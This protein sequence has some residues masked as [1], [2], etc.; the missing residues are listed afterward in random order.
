MDSPRDHR[1]SD[2]DR[3]RIGWFLSLARFLARWSTWITQL[4]GRR[5]HAMA[6][7]SW[8]ADSHDSSNTKRRHVGLPQE[9]LPTRNDEQAVR[10]AAL[11]VPMGNEPHEANR[12]DPPAPTTNAARNALRN[13]SS[14]PPPSP[15]LAVSAP[16]QPSNEGSQGDQSAALS[17]GEAASEL[18]LAP[19]AADHEA[20]PALPIGSG[21]ATE[22]VLPGAPNPDELEALPAAGTPDSANQ[23]L[24]TEAV[25]KHAEARSSTA[26]TAEAETNSLPAKTP[27]PAEKDAALEADTIDNAACDSLSDLIGPE[28]SAGEDILPFP[29]EA[30]P[31][32]PTSIPRPVSKYRPRLGPRPAPSPRPAAAETEQEQTGGSLEAILL[33]TFLPG[34]WGISLAVLLG[35]TET[36]RAP[37]EDRRSAEAGGIGL[38]AGE[39]RTVRRRTLHHDNTHCGS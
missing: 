33:L 35:R 28:I 34:D 37:D 6:P 5:T 20:V 9:Q 14:T 32:A 15:T 2:L 16:V 3:A 24:P 17:A 27:A 7:A 39:K 30:Q 31:E 1:L 4:R 19:S 8:P 36:M 10:L 29:N 11:L 18:R 23:R 21:R 25:V 38:N 22:T 12:A 13:A 26:E